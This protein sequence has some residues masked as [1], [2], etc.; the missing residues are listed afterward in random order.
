[1]QDIEF[2]IPHVHFRTENFFSLS[3]GQ[4]LNGMHY[5]VDISEFSDFRKI[6][7]L[8]RRCIMCINKWKAKARIQSSAPEDSNLFLLAQKFLILTDQQKHFPDV[9]E[10]FSRGLNTVKNI[11][12]IVSQMNLFVDQ[13]GIFRVK[14]KFKNQKIYPILL[15]RDSHL[16]KLIII[17]IHHK[18]AHS[19]C[20]AVLSELR[21]HYFIPK[22]FSIVKKVIRECVHCK[23]FNARPIN[24]NQNYYREFREDP[25]TVPFSNIFID[26]MGPFTV[27]FEK[28]NTKV[29]LLCFTCTWSRAVNL[30]ICRSLT[31]SDFL[32]AFS[33]HCF[34]FGIPQLCVS[35]LGSQIVAGA[36]VLTTFL[37]DPHT[38][39]YFEERGVKPLKFQHYFKGCSQLGS[40]VEI[41]VKLTKRLLYGCIKN[42]ILDY[43]DFEFIVGKVVHLVNRR[44]IAFKESL[45]DSETEDLP[46]LITPELL[47][48][49]MNSPL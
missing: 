12:D 39:L 43:F 16:T 21:R 15:S 29:W 38:Q 47:F 31:V 13:D 9:C 44:P 45:R 42:N 5:L 25:P 36:N 7:L 22:N 35:D 11:P 10:Y 27:K 17:D 8:Y 32:R 2:T 49:G 34:E 18:L 30:K 33:L 3:N 1:M 19:G 20:Y 40:L 26:Y 6:V 48:E 46:E 4:A 37:N 14:S 23:R 41:C 28:E 24:L